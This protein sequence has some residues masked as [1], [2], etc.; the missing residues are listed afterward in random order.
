MQQ[1]I[2]HLYNRLQRSMMKVRCSASRSLTSSDSIV[3]VLG[4][5]SEVWQCHFL[6]LLIVA[7]RALVYQQ[8]RQFNVST[9]VFPT[10]RVILPCH[11]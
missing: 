3:S 11:V 6:V 7:Q 10:V 2:V 1:E 8:K 5:H 9:C 4:L